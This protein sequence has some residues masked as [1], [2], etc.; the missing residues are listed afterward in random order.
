[1]LG[2]SRH[3]VVLGISLAIGSAL[4]LAACQPKPLTDAQVQAGTDTVADQ[5]ADETTHPD[6]ANPQDGAG[7]SSS[8]APGQADSQP[9]ADGAVGADATPEVDAAGKVDA[10]APCLNACDDGNPCT[11]DLCDA[12]SGCSSTPNTKACN[13]GNV[14]TTGDTCSAG[15]C[16]GTPKA[17]QAALGSKNPDHGTAIVGHS[18]GSLTAVG[19]YGGSVEDDFWLVRFGADGALAWQKQYGEPDTIESAYGLAAMANGGWLIVGFVGSSSA[20]DGRAVRVNSTGSVLWA[21]D[22]GTA[23]IEEF[24]GVVALGDGGAVAVG[25]ATKS[26]ISDLWMVRFSDKGDVA[27]QSALGGT[28]ADSGS[29]IISAT[30]GGFVAVG[31][32][33]SSGNTDALVIRTDSKGVQLWQKI[34]GEKDYADHATAVVASPAGGYLVVGDTT[35]AGGNMNVA[36]WHL[37]DDG[38]VLWSQAWGGPGIEL[39]MGVVAISDGFLIAGRSVGTGGAFTDGLLARFDP[40]GNEVWKKIFGGVGAD[41]FTGIAQLPNGFALV[42][43][44]LE[45]VNNPGMWLVR[46]D[47]WGNGDC[48]SAELC[49]APCASGSACKIAWCA[50]GA[51]MSATVPAG[52][53]CMESPCLVGSC[54]DK[55]ACVGS[56][57]V[58]CDDG[59]PCT[60]D[61]CSSGGG[62]SHAQASDG[63]P[64]ASGSV[65]KAGNCAAGQ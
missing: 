45:F 26:G 51:C 3:S 59:N 8:D 39:A 53:W 12:T 61:G 44:T 48:A 60:T 14:C 37:A 27:W 42:G 5:V 25:K 19:R 41:S 13:D 32:T 36:L 47:P 56:T 63:T 23:E 9:A 6:S 33:T 4:G 38:K 20:T 40:L 31:N 1:M 18:D 29:A 57:P 17:W 52:G 2:Q 55:K 21:Q 30:G 15:K 28:A 46:T 49:K 58:S 11:T 50:Q 10:A 24:R 7:D 64:C 22:V 34:I 35:Q 54:D 43:G 62:C 65:C 16:V